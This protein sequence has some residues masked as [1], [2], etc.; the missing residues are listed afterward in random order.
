M[1]NTLAALTG[2]DFLG[3]DLTVRNT[4]GPVGT[5]GLRTKLSITPSLITG[6][7]V[8]IHPDGSIGRVTVSLTPG[9]PSILL[10]LGSCSVIIGCLRRVCLIMED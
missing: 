5:S 4:A 9:L 2:Q 8:L 1:Q 10:S 7:L 6:V 3:V